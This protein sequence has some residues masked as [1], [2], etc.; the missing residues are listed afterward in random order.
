MELGNLS[1][2]NWKDGCSG[3]SIREQRK[4]FKECPFFGKPVFVKYQ[5]EIEDLAPIRRAWR[6]AVQDAIYYGGTIRKKDVTETGFYLNSGGKQRF[7]E[8][9][10]LER[11]AVFVAAG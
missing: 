2:V 6:Q 10:K 11:V 9:G 1:I 3:F 5:V 4:F 8:F 7:I